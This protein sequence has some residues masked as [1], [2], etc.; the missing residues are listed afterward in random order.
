MDKSFHFFCFY[1]EDGPQSGHLIHLLDI[2]IFQNWYTFDFYP[3]FHPYTIKYN[4]LTPSVIV[5]KNNKEVWRY[6]SDK[7]SKSFITT[8]LFEI[9]YKPTP[10]EI[11][12]R[13]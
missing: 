11:Y 10:Y 7:F 5:T 1:D 4:V 12:S 3:M 8:M 6:H 2:N 9:L 13:Y